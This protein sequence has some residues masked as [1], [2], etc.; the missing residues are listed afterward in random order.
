VIYWSIVIV[1]L[2]ADQLSKFV[3]MGALSLYESIPV[4]PGVF[5]LTY[6]INR[7]AAF[8]LLAQA[9]ASWRH[10][11]FVIVGLVAVT[12]LTILY[13]HIREEEPRQSLALPLIAGGALGNLLDRLRIGGVVDFLDFHWSGYHWPAFNIADSAI[14]IGVGIFL[15]FSFSPR[16]RKPEQQR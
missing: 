14:C 1:V 5:N 4:I 12:A 3:V 7:G 2:L 11:F 13:Y 9:D 6:V 15:L 16:G 8:S 10:P